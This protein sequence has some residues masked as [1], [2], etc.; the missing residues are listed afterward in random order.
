MEGRKANEQTSYIH[1]T[2]SAQHLTPRVVISCILTTLKSFISISATTSARAYS[3]WVI[4]VPA[5]FSSVCFI[6]HF[7]VSR[8]EEKLRI[9]IW[10]I[11]NLRTSFCGK[12]DK[13]KKEKTQQ[14]N[15]GRKDV[16][17]FFSG[18]DFDEFFKPRKK[19]KIFH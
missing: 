18:W 3:V 10:E 13:K 9:F 6:F 2:R 11:R 14:T 7:N 17:I 19:N 16:N 1:I 4:Y 15:R 8:E 12:W 5:F